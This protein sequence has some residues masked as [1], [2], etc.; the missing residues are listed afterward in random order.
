MATSP[1]STTATTVTLRNLAAKL[2]E[3]HEMSKKQ[4][5]TILNDLFPKLPASGDKA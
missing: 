3:E 1:K 2:A 4:S 5:E